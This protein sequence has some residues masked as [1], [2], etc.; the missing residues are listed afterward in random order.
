MGHP[1]SKSKS[2]HKSKTGSRRERKRGTW[3]KLR[4][5]S[6]RKKKCIEIQSLVEVGPARCKRD[7]VMIPI[8]GIAG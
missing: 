5:T 6:C 8:Y 4:S 3:L 7:V 1:R 2:K